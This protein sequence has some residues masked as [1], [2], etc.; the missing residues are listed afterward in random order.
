MNKR[1]LRDFRLLTIILT[2][3]LSIPFASTALAKPKGHGFKLPSH[4]LEIAPGLFYLGIAED[5]DFRPVQGFAIVDH[6][7]KGFG[8]KNNHDKGGG[9][10]G[11]GGG[12]WNI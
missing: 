10:N 6:P 11:G 12:G 3:G 5:V 4:A 2:L 7:R 8:H 9:P 1:I